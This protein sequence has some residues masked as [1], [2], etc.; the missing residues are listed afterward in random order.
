MEEGFNFVM[1]IWKCLEKSNLESEFL[2]A[3][4]QK[5]IEEIY[6]WMLERHALI[7]K[8]LEFEKRASCPHRHFQSF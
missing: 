3:I 6:Q 5:V 7:E 1:M 8:M 2:R 4:I